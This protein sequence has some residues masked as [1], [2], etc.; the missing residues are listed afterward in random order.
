MFAEASRLI[1]RLLR[2]FYREAAGKSLLTG[3]VIAHQMF[4][5]LL[6]CNPHF[7][8]IVFGGWL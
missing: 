1:Y 7:H 2:E 4:G 8:A 6:R 5:G 3:M